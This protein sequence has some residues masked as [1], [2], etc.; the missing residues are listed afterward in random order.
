MASRCDQANRARAG[1]PY[2][3]H[4]RDRDREWL[5]VTDGVAVPRAALDRGRARSRARGGRWPRGP[6][7]EV[8][9]AGG[10]PAVATQVRVGAGPRSA[11]RST[12]GSS[13]MNDGA[14]DSAARDLER[15]RAELRS[16][17]APVRRTHPRG[18]AFPRSAIMRTVLKP[19]LRWLWLGGLTALSVVVSRR[20][21]AGRL[22]PLL[23]AISTLRGA[24]QRHQRG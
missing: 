23:L 9:L 8:S 2:A 7:G 21:P 3:G 15:T 1:G 12:Q 16:L 4:Q 6:T 24:L 19:Q 17:I 13:L 5:A 10:S 20:V 11:R 18:D 22:N 14:N